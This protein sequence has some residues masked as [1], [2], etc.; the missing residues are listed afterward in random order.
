MK[1]LYYIEIDK[2][3]FSEWAEI[4]DVGEYQI[5]KLYERKEKAEERCW[6]LNRLY[7]DRYAYY[8]VVEVGAIEFIKNYIENL[9]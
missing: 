5:P 2:Q 3:G 9:D 1:K 7:R 4:E 8:K 6:Q